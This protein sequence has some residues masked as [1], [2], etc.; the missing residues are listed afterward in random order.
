M[1][2][3]RF[4]PGSSVTRLTYAGEAVDAIDARSV[5]LARAAGT[6]VDSYV[7]MNKQK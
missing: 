3:T 7:M 1:C 6:L 5:V 4:T 2:L